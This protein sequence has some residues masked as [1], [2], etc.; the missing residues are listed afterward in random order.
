MT[1]ALWRI[2]TPM[3]QEP[4]TPSAFVKVTVVLVCVRSGY[5]LAY[6]ELT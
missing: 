6:Y 5:R 4:S 1:T 2:A 3:E